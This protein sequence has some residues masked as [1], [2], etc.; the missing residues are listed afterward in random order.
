[1]V[2]VDAAYLCKKF[3][4]SSFSYSDLFLIGHILLG[5]GVIIP[6]ME[7][8]V[9]PGHIVLNGDPAPPSPKRDTAVP[10]FRPM[11]VVAKRLDGSRYQLVGRLASS[12]ATL[13]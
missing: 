8:V 10:N 13:C 9:G 2:A 7:A 4:N 5:Y 12:Q 6:S 3:V 1:M 11:F